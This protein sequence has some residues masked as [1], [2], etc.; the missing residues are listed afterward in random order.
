LL[1]PKVTS[2]TP[3]DE[4]SGVL[5]NRAV[6]VNFS[7]LLDPT[8][9]NAETF[10]LSAGSTEVSGVVSYGGT[11]ASFTPD[12]DLAANTEYTATL[13]T[14]ISDL[15]VNPLA[16]NIVWSFTTGT[17][18]AKGPAPVN[19][20]SASEFAILSKTGITNIPASAITGNIGASPITAAALNTVTCSEITGTIYGA[21]DGYTATCF[22]GDAAANTLVANA[23]LDMGA[24][25]RDAA[26][27]TTPDFTELY[28]GDLSGQ[29]LVPGLYKWGTDVLINSDVTLSGGANDVWILQIARDLIQAGSTQVTLTGGAQAKNVF[30][31]VGGG[32]GVTLDTG[33]YFNGIILAEKGITVNTG[34][35]V[36]GRL[37]SQTAVT[38]DQNKVTQPAL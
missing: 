6:S 9:V 37:L 14:G 17:D 22:E 27:R 24:A 16:A 30:W 34:A 32:T 4:V 8:T 2:T 3:V 38:L 21:D 23:V 25:Y 11:V 28:A 31:Q 33:A 15:A 5:L 26:G 20:G 7:E 35:T 36:N 29:T 13:T 18:V 12:S 1:A 10:S 19:L